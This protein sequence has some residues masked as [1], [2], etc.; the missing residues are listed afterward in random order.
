MGEEKGEHSY[1]DSREV[2]WYSCFEKWFGKYT[3]IKHS[4][5][6]SPSNPSPRWIWKRV[7]N[8]DPCKISIWMF[9]A[10]LFKNPKHGNNLHV[11]QWLIKFGIDK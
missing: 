5:N 7:E 10:S 4:T 8:T 1:F 2:K 3:K 11:Y 6:T 9:T